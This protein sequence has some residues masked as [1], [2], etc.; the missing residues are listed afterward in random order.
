M[1]IDWK[2]QPNED[3]TSQGW[4]DSTIAQFK[5]NRLESLTRET[6]QNSLDARRE[7]SKPVIVEFQEQSKKVDEIPNSSTLRSILGLCE[8][9]KDTQNP[10]MV[11]EL[12]LAIKSLNQPKV[13]VLSIADY[14]TTGMDGPCEP[15][16]PFYNY[17]KAVGQSGGST[18]RAGSHGLG[19][20]APLACST[21]RS[22][23]VATKWKGKKG[24]EGLLQ[25]R[26]VLMSFRKGQKIYKGTG[27][28]GDE[29]GYQ[30]VVPDAVPEKYQWLIRDSIGTTVHLLGWTS[31]KNWQQLIIGYAISSFFAAF[32]RNGLVLRVGDQEVN[33]SN[34]EELANSD[35]V[36]S[37]IRSEKKEEKLDDAMSYLGCL[38]DSEDVIKEESQLMPLGRTS[39]RLRVY[40]KAPRKIALIRNDMLITESIPGF[41]KRVPTKLGDFVGVVEVL[42]PEGSKLIRSMEPPAH[43]DLSKDWL[44]TPEEQRKGGV[45]LDR[46]ADE[47]KKFTERHAGGND[48]VATRIE[49]MA[50]F[51][52]DEA[53]DDRGQRI[54]EEFDPNGRFTFSPKHVKLLPPS[55]ISLNADFEDDIDDSDVISE[56]DETV[57]V[58][59]NIYG[60]SGGGARVN[61]DPDSD[62]NGGEHDGEGDG[63]GQEGSGGDDGESSTGTE[64]PKT[65]RDKPERELPLENVRI[66][67]VGSNQ[68]K[69]FLTS[70][71]TATVTLRVHEVGADIAI[72]F[73]ITATDKGNLTDGAI[74]L[75]LKS[76]ER[77]S[78]SVSLS[79]EIIGGL[80]LIAS[81]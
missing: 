14:N 48:D 20:G 67:K 6:I 50:D 52:E 28:W 80:K 70:P 19:K 64:K 63:D 44:P 39:I 79:R 30:A 5:S 61:A 58:D 8:K 47:L 53:G 77:F 25:G 73:E 10:D 75:K 24:V 27:Y 40:D 11:R 74:T 68:A 78:V 29:Q 60:G 71:M 59:P 7:P 9:E 66:V 23:I 17:V 15:G 41:W 51:F 42:D 49:F 2:F 12:S 26:A 16:N 35:A 72:P 57:T 3:G 32:E 1:K 69:V 21:L 56:P 45:A 62:S 43:N 55:R 18:A 38:K 36:R 22:I 81:Q 76:K 34:I 54:G 33:G 46:L 4:N 31:G 13:S 65:S 37:A